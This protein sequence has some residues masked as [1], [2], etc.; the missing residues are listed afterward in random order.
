VR[1]FHLVAP[2]AWTEAMTAGEYRPASLAAEGFVHFSFAE[3][4]EDVANARYASA[5]E[6]QVVEFEVPRERVV[7]EDSYG[8][9]TA[10]PHVYGHI[11]T[12]WAVTVHPLSRTDG[13]WRFSA[14][15]DRATSD[16]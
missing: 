9:G 3:Q 14:R 8:S 1:L 6:L 12:A 11:D 2:R 4:V 10:Y 5:L 16:P 13:R 7:V 15:S